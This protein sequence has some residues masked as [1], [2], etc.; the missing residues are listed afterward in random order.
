MLDLRISLLL[1]LLVYQRSYVGVIV[2]MQSFLNPLPKGLVRKWVL[3]RVVKVL[4]LFVSSLACCHKG[5]VEQ[6]QVDDE[7]RKLKL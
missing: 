3:K 7:D 6:K 1:N 4:E 5:Y 2:L